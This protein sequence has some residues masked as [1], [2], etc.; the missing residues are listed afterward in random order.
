MNADIYIH[1]YVTAHLAHILTH[2]Q[3]TMKILK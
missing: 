3:V 2:V 1:T